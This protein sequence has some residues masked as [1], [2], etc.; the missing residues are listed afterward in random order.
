MVP[1]PAQGIDLRTEA[2]RSRGEPL[3]LY[4]RIAAHER[5]LWV[6]TLA[7][8]AASA[9]TLALL[10]VTAAMFGVFHGPHRGYLLAGGVFVFLAAFILYMSSQRRRLEET[11]VR[12]FREL[13][14]RSTELAETN[15]SL[16]EALRTRD[17]FLDTVSHELKTPL[18]C[19]I[20]YSEFLAEETLDRA[21]ARE[22]ART[23]L[24]EARSLQRLIEQ[25]FEVTRIRSGQLSLERAD[26]DLGLLVHRVVERERAEAEARGLGLSLTLACEPLPARADSRRLD[27]ALTTLLRNAIRHSEPP[28]R[29]AVSMR[30]LDEDWA[31]IAI[32]DETD[33]PA[34]AEREA[35]EHPFLALDP[36]PSG[37]TGELGLGLPLVKR[38]VLA[39]GG[40][41]QVGDAPGRGIIFRIQLPLHGS[42]AADSDA[43][44]RP[45][46]GAP[47]LQRAS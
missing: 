30:R 32:R 23:I 13:E 4:R 22:H 2:P 24:R 7:V 42:R 46:A 21:Q 28:A 39:H 29:I 12:I 16:N 14:S 37:R 43:A 35:L 36:A 11:R 26:I 18:T 38:F 40:M 20:A 19:V 27:D 10:T 6:A 31:E 1:S 5:G 9:A 25:V 3:G 15:R 8:G 44:A 34:G 41:V 45:P 47:P 33:R 17:V